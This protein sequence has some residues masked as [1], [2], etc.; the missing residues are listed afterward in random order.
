MIIERTKFSSHLRVCG[1]ETRKERVCVW[2]ERERGVT[3]NEEASG[4]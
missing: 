4:R 3:V 2:G 1:D